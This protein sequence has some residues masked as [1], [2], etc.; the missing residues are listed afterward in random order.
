M[1]Y[2]DQYGNDVGDIFADINALKAT[3]D[4]RIK[5]VHGMISNIGDKLPEEGKKEFVEALLSKVTEMDNVVDKV[6]DEV[7]KAASKFD[8]RSN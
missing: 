8:E 2:K 4:K 5:G 3:L 7:R 6:E 1:D